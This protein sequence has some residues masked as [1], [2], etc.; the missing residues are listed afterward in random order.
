MNMPTGLVA[1]D[2][3][4][5]A[6]RHALALASHH[7]PRTA[8]RWTSHSDLEELLPTKGDIDMLIPAAQHEALASGSA[9]RDVA[10]K[11]TKRFVERLGI[12]AFEKYRGIGVFAATYMLCT[13]VSAEVL[14]AAANF[15]GL[16]YFVDD[17]CFDSEDI[18]HYQVGVRDPVC[19][20]NPAGYLDFLARICTGMLRSEEPPQ[21]P[22]GSDDGASAAN[23]QLYGPV[24]MAFWETGRDLRRL[25]ASSP[26][27]YPCFAD[28]VDDFIAACLSIQADFAGSIADLDKYT[29]A[30]VRNSGY[31][32]TALLL[33]LANQCF[34]PP[35]ARAH[36]GVQ[37]L[38]WAMDAHGS[39]LNDVFSYNKEVEGV[40]REFCPIRL[41]MRQQ[42]MSLVQAV[43]R[44]VELINSHASA[45]T[46]SA[47]DLEAELPPH[48]AMDPRVRRYVQAL[49]EIV[50]GSM[51]FHNALDRYSWPV[52]D[53]SIAERYHLTIAM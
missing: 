39:L 32:S 23:S 9:Y 51:H 47:G 3:A 20:R 10:D 4:L 19:W 35:E 13:S 34:L 30:R 44:V 33:E 15:L 27:W 50:S 38:V 21:L 53:S 24:A 8:R 12:Q 37:R 1:L 11:A 29:V 40:A 25:S 22:L 31:Y 17:L 6:A 48:L 16:L 45:F 41:L 5:A 43:R 14:T 36:R 49:R 46:A 26:D 42:G 52:F 18:P 28:S 2:A 7:A